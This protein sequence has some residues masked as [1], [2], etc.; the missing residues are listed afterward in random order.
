MSTLRNRVQL[1][2]RLGKN[3]E[4]KNFDN[5]KK[6]ATFSLATSEAYNNE[7]GER[8]EKTEWHNVVAWGKT[9]EI[10]EKFV[11]KGQEISIEGKLT[12]RN[13]DDKEG[14]KRYV[15]EV[16]V[17][18]VLLMGNSNNKEKQPF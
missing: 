6:L 14:V 12:S 9:A 11:T 13:Y 8:V 15:T 2:G 4:I 1:V 5:N 16:V 7:K 3:P 10:I 18:E 17:S